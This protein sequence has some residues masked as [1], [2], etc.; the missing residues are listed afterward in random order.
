MAVD[1]DDRIWIIE[2]GMKPSRLVGFDSRTG[3]F[4]SS[5]DI[6]SGGGSVRNMYYFEPAGELWFGTE[7]N[8]I[9][10]AGIY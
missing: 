7:T 1:R 6:P 3:S 8:Y 2:T 4:F 5:T 10:R 9:G